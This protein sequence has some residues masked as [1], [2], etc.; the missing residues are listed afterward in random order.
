M[1]NLH[2]TVAGFLAEAQEI[3]DVVN[4]KLTVVATTDTSVEFDLGPYVLGVNRMERIVEAGTA[5][6]LT[7]T[8]T[9][10]QAPR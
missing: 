8:I 9:G 10:T 7:V 5:R 3:A 4:A 1:T 2:P 6:G